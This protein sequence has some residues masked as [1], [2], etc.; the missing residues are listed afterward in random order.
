MKIGLYSTS[1][2]PSK[3]VLEGYGGVE[4]FVGSLAEYY[5]KLGHEVHLFAAKGS[6]KPKN[7]YLYE[8]VCDDVNEVHRE[9]KMFD[10]FVDKFGYD[11]FTNLDILHDNSHWHIPGAVLVP[12]GINYTFTLHALQTHTENFKKELYKYNPIALSYDYSR[13]IQWLDPMNYRVVQDGINLE[14]YPYKEKKNDRLLWLSRIFPPKG[15]HHAIAIAEKAKIP[16]DIVGGSPIDVPGY[17]DDIKRRCK[18]SEYANFIGEV[19]HKDKI[20][21]LQNARAVILP[22]ECITK[23]LEGSV[24]LWIEAACMIPL[25]ANA[26][27]TPVIAS[28][29]GM[30]GEV[31]SEGVNGFLAISEND[32]VEKIRRLD[33]IKP[34]QCRCRAEYFSF[35]KTAENFLK[36]YHD[37][38]DGNTW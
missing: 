8:F 20:Q 25:E 11:I 5:D 15:A 21:Y 30:I 17:L 4:P 35:N 10:S 19:S 38:L 27:G 6:Y 37:I 26:C 24:S 1:T 12:K 18:Y 22:I 2:L 34:K 36:R 31:I 29:N 33:E 14:H 28:P 23:T 9:Q 32:F 13:F 3:P 16:I 7:G